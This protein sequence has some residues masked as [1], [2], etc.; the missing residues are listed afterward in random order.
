MFGDYVPGLVD[1]VEVVLCDRMFESGDTQGLP[2]RS[3]EDRL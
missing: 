1:F 3:T 2:S